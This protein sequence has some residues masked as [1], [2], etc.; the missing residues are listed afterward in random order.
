MRNLHEKYL[1]NIL[2]QSSFSALTSPSPYLVGCAGFQLCWSRPWTLKP[3]PHRNL[4]CRNANTGWWWSL[5]YE[6]GP[7]GQIFWPNQQETHY[8][9]S[10]WCSDD[11]WLKNEKFL[12][13][14]KIP[15]KGFDSHCA[16]NSNSNFRFSKEDDY[17]LAKLPFL[18]MSPFSS[19]IIG[20]LLQIFMPKTVMKG[21][22]FP[23]QRH[24]G[25][26]WKFDYCIFK[27]DT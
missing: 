10:L 16:Q 2:P 25:K 8:K 17:Y 23:W 5:N 20:H 13:D 6:Y 3:A 12:T 19:I 18:R 22:S 24:R 1:S 21:Q 11:T 27:E 4:I 15:V 26:I 14:Q 7:G 9:T